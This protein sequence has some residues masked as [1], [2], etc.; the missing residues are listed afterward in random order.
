V[1]FT[2]PSRQ[3]H[4]VLQNFSLVIPVGSIVALCGSSGSG[5]S[6]VGQLVE[7]FYDVDT[8]I[9]LVD[10]VDIKNLNPSWLRRH[11]GYINQEP[12]LFATTILENIRYGSPDATLEQV[13][14]AARQ[15]N[16]SD[17]ISSFPNGYN[18][19]V[20]ERGVTLSGGQKQAKYFLQFC[21]VNEFWK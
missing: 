19:T 12:I 4:K 13:M 16:A 21:F 20:G 2:Y 18:T 10:G 7:R 15:A 3:E 8:G 9:V 1:D 5:K 11:I 17:F 6:T 14:E